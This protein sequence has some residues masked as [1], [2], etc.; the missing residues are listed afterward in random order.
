MGAENRHHPP[1]L[2][3]RETL[4]AMQT[5][6]Q[7]ASQSG[8]QTPPG[9][10]YSQSG[11]RPGWAGHGGDPLLWPWPLRSK[12]TPAGRAGPRGWGWGWGRISLSRGKLMPSWRRG[13]GAPS[14]TG[15]GC[16]C[17]SNGEDHLCVGTK[18]SLRPSQA[19]LHGL[20]HPA[21]PLRALL[22]LGPGLSRDG[23]AADGM[24]ALGMFLGR[25]V[26]P[27]TGFLPGAAW[28][29]G[30]EQ[31]LSLSPRSFC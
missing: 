10:T 12:A 29:G 14:Q 7:F 24:Y 3:P 8:S 23:V 20:R 27:G 21:L 5:C 6:G 13:E 4:S 22:T 2:L 15:D 9:W 11:P 18:G 31:P 25:S 28:A 26:L 30:R 16:Q 17:S 1:R 19:N